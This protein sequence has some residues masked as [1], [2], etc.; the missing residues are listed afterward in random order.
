MPCGFS[1]T[2][3]LGMGGSR[4][5]GAY[6]TCDF[7]DHLKENTKLQMQS[8]VRTLVELWLDHSEGT[9]GEIIEGRRPGE[10]V[11]CSLY[12]TKECV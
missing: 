8:K 10:S 7:R 6:G 2:K 5:C 12:W 11:P 4:F 9:L 1:G 3:A